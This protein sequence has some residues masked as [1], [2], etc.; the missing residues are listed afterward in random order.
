MNQT[1]PKVIIHKKDRIEYILS[2]IE[3]YYNIDRVE[4][5][6]KARTPERHKV[7]S[8]T[9]KILRD[10][11]DLSFKEIRFLYNN[12]SENSVW[13][14][15]NKVSEKIESKYDCDVLVRKEYNSI[16]KSMGL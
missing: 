12:T 7:K 9:V 1:P 14:M 15:H 6:K 16:L 2:G 4:L 3:N 11:A 5:L 8:F 10:I 13:V